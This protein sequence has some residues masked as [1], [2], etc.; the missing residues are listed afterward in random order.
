MKNLF[1]YLV[2]FITFLSFAQNAE[3]IVAKNIEVSGGLTNWK[4]LNSIKLKG[5]VNLNLGESF[6]VEIIQKRENLTKTIFTINNKKQVIEGY[7]GKKAYQMN[8]ST[9]KIE[10]LTSYQPESF[11]SDLINYKEKGFKMEYVEQTKVYN[12]TCY[13]VKFTKENKTTFYYFNVKNYQLEKEEN[14]DEII[15][16]GEYKKTGVY[17]F[18]F[19]I[20]SINKRDKSSFVM[21]LNK[22]EINPK[23]TIKDFRR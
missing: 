5:I 19:R 16:Y 11:E 6:P 4:K 22:I 1:F 23:L 10:T 12:S 15:F 18:A 9:N 8:F 17:Q 21:E 13:K 3:E 14:D 20:E 2:F 7:D